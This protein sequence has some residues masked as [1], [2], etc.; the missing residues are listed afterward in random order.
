MTKKCMSGTN[1]PHNHTHLSLIFAALEVNHRLRKDQGKP[2]VR[3]AS[4]GKSN[5]NN[6]PAM[7][8]WSEDHVSASVLKHCWG[9][10]LLT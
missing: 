2:V 9:K 10:K 6:K 8:L 4:H 1:Q 3:I 7:A 5:N